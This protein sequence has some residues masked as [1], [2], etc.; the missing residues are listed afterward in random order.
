MRS[1]R[2]TA[3]LLAA[4]AALVP[5]GC[6]FVGASNVSHTKPNGFV[7]RG[8]VTVPLP[9]TDR[10]AAGAAC[11][12]PVA[13]PD[14]AGGAPV[15]VTDPAGHE[16]A[17]GSLGAGIVARASAAPGGSGASCDFP[18][19]IRAVP[20]GVASYGISVAGRPA[21]TFPARSLR[22]DQAA[23]IRIAASG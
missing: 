23:V 6:G 5:A 1:V 14:I 11:A 18:F 12:A 8:R 10:R 21:Q 17:L 19:E 15:K 3:V 9:G 7:L 13:L 20:G 22:E 4:L 2:R 16:I